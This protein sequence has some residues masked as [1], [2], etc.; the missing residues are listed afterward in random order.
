M[1][2]C[3]PHR[4]IP[5]I[6]GIAFALGPDL[7]SKFLVMLYA[8]N[9]MGRG[10]GVEFRY[11]FWPEAPCWHLPKHHNHQLPLILS[12]SYSDIRCAVSHITTVHLSFL[13]GKLPLS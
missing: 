5:T 1:A 8:V 13:F 4:V 7:S 3:L 9:R 11:S 2:S 10:V 6:P 12:P